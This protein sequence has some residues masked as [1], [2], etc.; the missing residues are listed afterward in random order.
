MATPLSDGKVYLIESDAGDNQN[1]VPTP[2]NIDLDNFI[3]GDEYCVLSIPRQW[4]QGGVTGIQADT[5][6]GGNGFMTRTWRRYYI[7][8]MVGLEAIGAEAHYVDEFIMNNRH[9]ATSGATFT[10]YYLVIC[11]DED[12]ATGYQKFTNSAGAQVDYCKGVVTDF[13]IIWQEG[14]NLRATVQFTFMSVW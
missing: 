9:T 7:V 4:T 11:R 3:Q 13:Q 6:S 8:K 1:W 2:G 5:A 10:D 12:G 14:K